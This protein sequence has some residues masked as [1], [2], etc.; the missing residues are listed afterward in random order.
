MESLDTT[1]NGISILSSNT[2]IPT[3]LRDL[4]MKGRISCRQYRETSISH[5]L[6]L[7]VE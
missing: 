6:F 2:N 5:R 4:V 1:V 7:G 3:D